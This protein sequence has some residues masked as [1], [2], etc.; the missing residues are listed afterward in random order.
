MDEWF[1]HLYRKSYEKPSA[2]GIMGAVLIGD[3]SGAEAKYSGD[4]GQYHGS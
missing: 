2:C 1:R 4:L 3:I